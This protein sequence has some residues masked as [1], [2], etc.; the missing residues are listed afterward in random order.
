MGRITDIEASRSAMGYDKVMEEARQLEPARFRHQQEH[1]LGSERTRQ[2]GPRDPLGVP[3]HLIFGRSVR[4]AV[5]VH[6][7]VGMVSAQHNNPTSS[8][9][10]PT[11]MVVAS[12]LRYPCQDVTVLESPRASIQVSEEFDGRRRESNDVFGDHDD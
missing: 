7:S 9:E 10:S 2:Q 4:S 1:Q 12:V 3:I 5:W 8:L 6:Q 11:C